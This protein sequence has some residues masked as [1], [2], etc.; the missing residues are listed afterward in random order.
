MDRITGFFAYHA[1]P[2]IPSKKEEHEEFV[3]RTLRSFAARKL[4]FESKGEIL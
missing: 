2:V 1:Y 3:L 4:N